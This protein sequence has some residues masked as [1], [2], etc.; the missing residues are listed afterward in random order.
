MDT[1]YGLPIVMHR[2]FIGLNPDYDTPL[3]FR[4][5]LGQVTELNAENSTPY[6]LP[7]A[8]QVSKFERLPLEV[9]VKI[10]EYCEY[11]NESDANNH[12]S[13]WFFHH[14]DGWK[15]RLFRYKSGPGHPHRH[16][17]LYVS[18]QIQEELWDHT[19]RE[20]TVEF[21]HPLSDRKI[22]WN[23]WDNLFS[24]TFVPPKLERMAL[25]TLSFQFMR[26]IYLKHGECSYADGRPHA[27]RLTRRQQRFRIKLAESIKFLSKHCPLFVSFHLDIRSGYRLSSPFQKF[28]T[29]IVALQDPV[30]QCRELE[31]L[32]IAA[33]TRP[34]YADSMGHVEAPEF[35][36][37]KKVYD[38]DISPVPH[39]HRVDAVEQWLKSDLV[40]E[41]LTHVVIIKF[42]P[43]QEVYYWEDGRMNFE[44]VMEDAAELGRLIDARIL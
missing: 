5:D 40:R 30:E 4:K 44:H 25:E 19:L 38:L 24:S 16:N 9:R 7:K 43:H 22:F 8:R 3:P 14:Y 10:Y 41:A 26:R 31:V 2:P 29:V 33:D 13:F 27:Y 42:V 23:I 18:R 12:N 32:G 21:H 15:D 28:D 11:C 35:M 37:E 6:Q 36:L 39:H 1:D 34:I 17:L 20:A